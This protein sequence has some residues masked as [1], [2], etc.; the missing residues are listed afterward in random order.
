MSDGWREARWNRTRSDREPF[1]MKDKDERPNGTSR[2]CF[3]HTEAVCCW[4]LLMVTG[5]E[6]CSCVLSVLSH[7]RLLLSVF[8]LP[9]D[10][11]HKRGLCCWPVSISLSVRPSV[12]FMYRIQTAKDIVKFLSRPD[13]SVILVFDPK[14]DT[15]LQWQPL[16][17][18]L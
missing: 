17:W 7:P 1:V 15:Q 11:M 9:Y 16:Q 6:A 10:A 8:F 12:T 13:S 4:G 14:R 18:G 2:W 3:V 5:T